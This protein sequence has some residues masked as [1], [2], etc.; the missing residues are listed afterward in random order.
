[1]CA[2]NSHA[3]SFQTIHTG[4]AVK[5][6]TRSTHDSIRSSQYVSEC[7]FCFNLKKNFKIKIKFFCTKD[8]K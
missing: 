2:V 4:V 6:G 1:M 5:S 7:F 8:L 3:I